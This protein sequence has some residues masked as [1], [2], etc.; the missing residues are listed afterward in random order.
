MAR[1]IGGALFQQRS[2]RI[3][4]CTFSQSPTYAPAVRSSPALPHTHT[5][6]PPPPQEHASENGRGVGGRPS[7]Q[8]KRQYAGALSGNVGSN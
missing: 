6:A 8:N 4:L 3:L 2:K 5:S 7:R 1:G